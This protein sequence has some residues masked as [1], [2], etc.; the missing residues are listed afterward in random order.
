ML[1]GL[2]VGGQFLHEAMVTAPRP[3]LLPSR[4][5]EAGMLIEPVSRSNASSGVT[6]PTM[7]CRSLKGRPLAAASASASR[8]AAFSLRLMSRSQ[9]GLVANPAT[10]SY[11]LTSAVDAVRW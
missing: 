3:S 6:S 4:R 7:T 5:G 8:R 10:L 9:S 11:R 1:L 2:G